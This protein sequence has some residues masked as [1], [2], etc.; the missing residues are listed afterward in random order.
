MKIK[1]DKPIIVEGKYD[2]IRLENIFDAPIITTE[3]FGIFKNTEKAA[4]IKA[5]AK[6]NGVII[7]TDSDSAG[8]LIRGHIK[9]ILPTDKIINIYLPEIEG[10]ER[11]KSAPSKQGLLGVEGIEVKIIIDAF[12]NAGITAQKP[13]GETL[14]KLDLYNMGLVGGADSTQRRRRL[15]KKLELPTSLSTN[16]LLDA[17]NTLYTKQEFIELTER[18]D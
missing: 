4:M 17:I 5:L 14:T 7:L 9:S 11:R 16:A 6:K 15:L 12:Q 13:Q 8:N 2:K 10:K 18:K 1:L 3:G